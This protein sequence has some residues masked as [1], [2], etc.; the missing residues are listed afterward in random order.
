MKYVIIISAILVGIYFYSKKVY[1][2]QYIY[3]DLKKNPV[4]AERIIDDW[5]VK[6]DELCRQA[7]EAKVI[8]ATAQECIER[9]GKFGEMCKRRI[10]K[11]HPNLIDDLDTAK[12]VGRRF[13]NCIIP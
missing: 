3:A 9:A 2:E 11:D 1:E 7:A 8:P 5:D 12:Q 10:I 13:L 6:K 4:S